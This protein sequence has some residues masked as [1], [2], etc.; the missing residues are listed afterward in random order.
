MYLFINK[1]NSLTGKM[2]RLPTEAEWE[3]AARGGLYS[4]GFRFAGGNNIDEVAW[5]NTK[6]FDSYV[7]PVGK[8][9]PNELGLNDMTGN[10]E[11]WCQDWFGDYSDS[12]Q[13]N[14]RGPS[15]GTR[16]VTRGNSIVPVYGGDNNWF[17]FVSFREDYD[18]NFN[19]GDFGFRLA[20]DKM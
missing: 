18:P 16:R 12:N 3:F 7:R 4:K 5:N 19:S 6:G 17:Y 10:V 9:A 15:T 14:P 8:K 20:C 11:E 13:I 1:L 2:F